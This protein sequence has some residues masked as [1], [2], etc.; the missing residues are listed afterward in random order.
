MGSPRLQPIFL[1][2][3]AIACW[4]ALALLH[5]F[6]N[7]TNSPHDFR[8]CNMADPGEQLEDLESG[9]LNDEEVDCPLELQLPC[10][11]AALSSL[12]EHAMNA[13]TIAHTNRARATAMAHF[14][15]CPPRSQPVPTT[16]SSMYLYNIFVLCLTCVTLWFVRQRLKRPPPAV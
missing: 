1:G 2:K 13:I 14:S 3:D 8:C 11:R 6:R 15:L 16:M 4:G 9:Q 12:H 5:W 7:S 10:Q